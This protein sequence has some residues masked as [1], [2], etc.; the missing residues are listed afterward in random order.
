MVTKSF[1]WI[2]EVQA[3]VVAGV[4]NGTPKLERRLIEISA[5]WTRDVET[6]RTDLKMWRKKLS[7]CFRKRAA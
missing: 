7:G 3:K 4:E 1:D 6:R 2:D 5:K